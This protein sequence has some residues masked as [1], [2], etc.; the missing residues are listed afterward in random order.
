[1]VVA[2]VL[3]AVALMM[4]AFFS[5][6]ET[7]LYRVSRTKLVLDGL[8]GSR[9]ARGILWLL[10][11]PAIFIATSLVGNNLANYLISLAVVI[12]SASFFGSGSAAELFGPML[13]TPVVFVFGE[14]MPKSIFFRAPYRLIS[15]TSPVIIAV[16]A[17]LSPVA[18]L[19]GMLAIA[20]Q[21][22]T[23]QTPFP[24][25]LAMARSELDQLFRHGQEAGIL[26]TGQRF[27]AQRLLD[28][29]DRAA[30][31]Y[32][33]AVDRLAVID[34]PIDVKEARY[35]ARRA[36]HPI[37]LV[38]RAGRIVGF[39][40]YADLCA[41]KPLRDWNPVVRSKIEDRHLRV[42]LK[43]YDAGSEVA[44][45]RGE[46]GVVMSVVTRRQLV[47]PLIKAM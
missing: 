25:R 14:L 47:Q 18:A 38:R 12:A 16:A 36:N 28:V 17:V 8:G 15:A 46:G 40:W 1:M 21:R 44:V 35:R 41:S 11:H 24:I 22:I 33:V 19:L 42:L 27:L 32:G 3:F 29:G 23:G 31:S 43:L 45:L 37:V 9:S 39:V 4:S 7:G 2:V 30:I 34:A 20:L 5:G 13:I 10:N 6:T 26:G